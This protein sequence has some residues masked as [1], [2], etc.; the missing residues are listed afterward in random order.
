MFHVEIS[1]FYTSWR[2]KLRSQCCESG[3]ISYLIAFKKKIVITFVLAIGISGSGAGNFIS[4][5][6]NFFVC[7]LKICLMWWWCLIM[8][9]FSQLYSAL[10]LKTMFLQNK[11][12]ICEIFCIAD[13]KTFHTIK[14]RV[15][16]F[17]VYYI[18]CDL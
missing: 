7:I 8:I 11:N 2:C 1:P 18:E 14:H 10:L 16:I 17:L 9:L 15:D 6:V 4:P 13:E 12:K 3:F 5:R